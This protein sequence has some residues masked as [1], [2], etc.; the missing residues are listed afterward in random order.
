[1]VW[2][3]GRQRPITELLGVEVAAS[4][5]S[6]QGGALGRV[7]AEIV[8]WRLVECQQRGLGVG[9]VGFLDRDLRSLFGRIRG[10][11][12]PVSAIIFFLNAAPAGGFRV[13]DPTGSGGWN[14]RY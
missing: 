5:S 13:A 9:G 11:I 10:K 6:G 3:S 7:E 8:H 14:G 2:G 1:V 12:I 4:S